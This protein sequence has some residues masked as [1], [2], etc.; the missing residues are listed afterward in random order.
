MKF[1]NKLDTILER[2][3]DYLIILDYNYYT[4]D[5]INPQGIMDSP[6]YELFSE[7]YDELYDIMKSSIHGVSDLIE[8]VIKTKF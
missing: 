2:Y 8:Y 5:G 3:D 7:I 1:E 4:N 6:L